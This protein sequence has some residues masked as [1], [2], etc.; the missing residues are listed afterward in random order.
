MDSFCVWTEDQRQTSVFTGA[1]DEISVRKEKIKDNSVF[2][3][4]CSMLKETFAFGLDPE[5]ESVV[6]PSLI[7]SMFASKSEK[8][9]CFLGKGEARQC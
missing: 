8:S 7:Q 3:F 6:D 1:A 5:K 9:K 2:P 4:K